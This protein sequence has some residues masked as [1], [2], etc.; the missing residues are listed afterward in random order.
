MKNKIKD[1]L[2]VTLSTLIVIT[3]QYFFFPFLFRNF[4]EN[5]KYYNVRIELFLYISVVITVFILCKIFMDILF[6]HKK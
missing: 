5:I 3:I 4:F 6:T 2:T 1:V